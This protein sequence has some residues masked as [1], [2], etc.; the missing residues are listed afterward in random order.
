[1]TLITSGRYLPKH[2]D[3]DV[4]PLTGPG[5]D[6]IGRRRIPEPDWLRAVARAAME[7][8]LRRVAVETFAGTGWL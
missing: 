2:A 7:D 1:M 5:S 6:Y 4:A 8:A 3:P